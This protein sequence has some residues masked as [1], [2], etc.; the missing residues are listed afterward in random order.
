M[1]I[2]TKNC[3]LKTSQ[4]YQIKV[5]DDRASSLADFSSQTIMIVSAAQDYLYPIVGFFGFQVSSLMVSMIQFNKF[6][7]FL[8]L[9]KIRVGGIF[10]YVNY[11]LHENKNFELPFMVSEGDR[12]LYDYEYKKMYGEKLMTSSDI[13]NYLQTVL[14]AGV[15]WNIALILTLFQESEKLTKFITFLKRMTIKGF[16]SAGNS[17]SLML[18]VSTPLYLKAL[19]MAGNPYLIAFAL[20]A[21]LIIFALQ[22]YTY[23]KAF[24]FLIYRKKIEDSLFYYLKSEDM[25]DANRHI[26]QMWVIEQLFLFVSVLAMYHLRKNPVIML[27]TS[28]FCVLALT[29]VT[30]KKWRYAGKIVLFFK[31]FSQIGLL[32]FISLMLLQHYWPFVPVIAFDVIYISSN[33]S[34]LGETIS[35][36]IWISYTNKNIAQQVHPVKTESISIMP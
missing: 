35:F 15:I 31:M 32:G 13:L 7:L 2:T 29:I 30:T 36:V 9:S 1:V 5:S 10:D 34:K 24:D 19:Q 20:V 8:S 27:I 25:Y 22:C 11:N 12:Y 18:V 4:T 6:Y 3:S 28:L 26:I 21:F 17:V 33:F 23:Y 16:K 14:V